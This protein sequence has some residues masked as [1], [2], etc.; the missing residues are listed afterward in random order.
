MFGLRFV[1]LLQLEVRSAVDEAE[2]ARED[3]VSP[4]QPAEAEPLPLEQLAREDRVKLLFL[5]PAENPGFSLAGPAARMKVEEVGKQLFQ[6]PNI[7]AE[8]HPYFRT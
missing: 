5:L 4:F 7:G 2:L 8:A 6:L 1:S 3:A